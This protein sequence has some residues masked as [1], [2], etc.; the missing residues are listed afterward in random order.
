M[1]F[2]IRNG[3]HR[4]NIH[5][6]I[7]LIGTCL[8]Y[9]PLYDKNFISHIETSDSIDAIHNGILFKCS[10]VV[11]LTL[12]IVLF[13]DLLFDF[14]TSLLTQTKQQRVKDKKKNDNHVDV[15]LKTEMLV[16]LAGIVVKPLTS[17]L[18]YGAVKDIVLFNLICG[19]VEILLISG[20]I[21]AS[22]NRFDST[23]FPSWM[24]LCALVLFIVGQTVFP[25]YINSINYD[26]KLYLIVVICTWIGAVV[27]FLLN[28]NYVLD[29]I[30]FTFC[31]FQR[32]KFPFYEYCCSRVIPINAEVN[33]NN[34]SKQSNA[35]MQPYTHGHL[36]FRLTYCIMIMVFILVR[37]IL[38]AKFPSLAYLNDPILFTT[39]IPPILLAFCFLLFN[40][41]LVKHEAVESLISLLDA[42]KSYVRYISHGMC[43]SF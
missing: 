41:R 8:C 36:F 26:A 30:L 27:S 18:P 40:L 43:S 9:I 25:Y 1:R 20:S 23:C 34:S 33:D 14:M 6:L 7:T 35:A 11:A 16:F 3:N 19:R 22:L 15:L 37:A 32:W 29:T 28:A 4:S 21:A 12:A 13:F 17:F 24:T 38:I 5:L 10:A 2:V 42:K 39:E 31:G